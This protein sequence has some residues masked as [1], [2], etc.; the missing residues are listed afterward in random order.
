MNGKNY[1]KLPENYY[2]N[3]IYIADEKYEYYMQKYKEGEKKLKEKTIEHFFP[4]I[5]SFCEKL[6]LT[7]I[8]RNVYNPQ[9]E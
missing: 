8:D 5:D 9:K 3:E 1:T 7:L 4:V 2:R 6:N